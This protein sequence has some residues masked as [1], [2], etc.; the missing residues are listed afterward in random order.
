MTESPLNGKNF[1][2]KTGITSDK[3]TQHTQTCH[4]SSGKHVRAIYTP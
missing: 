3:H 4:I 1:V 2:G